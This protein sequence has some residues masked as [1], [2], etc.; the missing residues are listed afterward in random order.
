MP[1]RHAATVTDLLTDL[2]ESTPGHAVLLG[3]GVA[4]DGPGLWRQVRHGV[5]E[6]KR[7]GTTRETR[8]GLISGNC[9]EAVVAFLA[10]AQVGICVPI[11]PLLTSYELDH[12]INSMSVGIL[13]VTNEADLDKLTP[14]NPSGPMPHW[15]VPEVRSGD[16]GAPDGPVMTKHSPVPHDTCLLLRTSGTTA[17]PKVVPLTHQNL[18][19][20]A[21]GISANLKLTGQ[22]TGLNVMP[23]FHI[24]GLVA[25]LLAQLSVGGA[26][27]VLPP[28]DPEA[29]LDVIG[30]HHITWYSAVP[31]IHQAVVDA[32]I[33]Q[34]SPPRHQLRFV[35]SCSSPMTPRLLGH[36][37]E[38]LGVP[39][40]EAY[41]MT[42]AS[43]E[44]SSNPLPPGRRVPGSVGLPS[45]AEVA[46]LDDDDNRLPAKRVGAIYVRGPG[47][48]MGYLDDP[49]ANQH[50]FSGD[51]LRT[52]DIGFMDEEG[53]L[54]LRG[55]EKEMINRGGK[56]I[57]PREIDE[58]LVRHPDVD[59]ALAFAI[60]HPR[61]GEEV[62]AAIV[63]RA[64][65]QVTARDVQRFASGF[66]APFK[67]PRIVVTV[68]ELP[69]GPTGKP[70][71]IGMAERLN[72]TPGDLPGTSADPATEMVVR[73]WS[74]VMGRDGVSEEDNFFALGGDSLLAVWLLHKVNDHFGTVLPAS[75]VSGPGATPRDMAEL[76]GRQREKEAFPLA[77]AEGPG[78]KAGQEI[79]DLSPQQVPVWIM[80]SL[81]PESSMLNTSLILEL[82]GPLCER[83]LRTAFGKVIDRHDGLRS[84][85]P[86][87]DGHPRAVV[88]PTA[89]IE[90]GKVTVNVTGPESCRALD[91]L[92]N[93]KQII[94]DFA[95]QPFDISGFPLRAELLRLHQQRHILV[96]AI[97]HLVSDAWS[98]AVLARDLLAEYEELSGGRPARLPPVNVRSADVAA[99]QRQSLNSSR[100]DSLA[101]WRSISAE[102]ESCGRLAPGG[103]RPEGEHPAGQLAMPV[104]SRT[105]SRVAE[106]AAAMKMSVF[107][108][109]FGELAI[110]LGADAGISVGVPVSL[111][112]HPKMLDLV[113]YYSCVI[114]V[115]M[116]APP[117]ETAEQVISRTVAAYR[118]SINHAELPLDE[119][120]A[121][122][123]AG[124]ESRTALFDVVVKRDVFPVGLPALTTIQATPLNIG[125]PHA[126]FPLVIDLTSICGS[127]PSD[128]A[129]I[130]TFDYDMKAIS[131]T[132]IEHL[133]DRYS[134]IIAHD[135]LD[136]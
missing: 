2:R 66:L 76:I 59:Q 77:G 65:R 13:A 40:I 103:S 100:E 91:K 17:R 136:A 43:H 131:P 33:R 19:A 39:V 80:Q 98:R 135:G 53:Y 113:G 72:M 45:G 90:L 107:E 32:L 14:S 130:I 104:A 8:I 11:D 121:T 97:H 106:C 102:L 94:H 109:L 62:A 126:R 79:N 49:S 20:S 123:G 132:Q 134:R 112:R 30:T 87:M 71:R 115:K 9:P 47:V 18:L 31:T 37:E 52:G 57:F 34:E 48:M 127:T 44:I 101:H 42:E 93:V 12:Y 117:F 75:S 129:D 128:Q 105:V 74:E 111:R 10:I 6:L 4:V 116:H 84:R 24:H 35:R 27:Y 95:D 110:L 133:A 38:L 50:E 70:Q 28:G 23:L 55:R 15:I 73:I 88:E 81:D 64:G 78:S 124:G 69:K 56:K 25:G 7:L 61:L 63:T 114:P 5:G 122:I 120:T 36:L 1:S 82:V 108:L 89:D 118:R 54:H 51:W 85:F 92:P 67:V 29:I 3:P 26:V 68:R 46:I 96:V 119:L 83:S 60:D 125:Y 86:Y 16:Q 41:G 21:R 58:V 22:D 99:W